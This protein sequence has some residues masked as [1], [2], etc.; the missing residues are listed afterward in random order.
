MVHKVL[1]WLDNKVLYI[2]YIFYG[3]YLAGS[4]IDL[5]TPESPQNTSNALCTDHWPD[6]PRQQEI[7]ASITILW[8]QYQYMACFF[9]ASFYDTKYF[10]DVRKY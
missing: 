10:I 9:E 2:L 5:F 3:L 8:G 7:F 1:T 6:I 4:T